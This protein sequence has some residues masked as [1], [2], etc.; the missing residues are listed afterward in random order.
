MANPII[1]SASK[2]LTFSSIFAGRTNLAR[3]EK[4]SP[5]W[6]QH[7]LRRIMGI[8]SWKTLALFDFD[9]TITT[10]ETMPDF[11]RHSISRRRL[12]IGWILLAPMVAGYKVGLVSGRLIR[13]I[14]V[15]F[16]Y[17]GMPASALAIRGRDFAR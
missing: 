11:L 14:L 7:S 13:G 10:H 16:A 17:A 15:R 1:F 9:G 3:F 12:V 2:I 5:S 4:G 6:L 8:D